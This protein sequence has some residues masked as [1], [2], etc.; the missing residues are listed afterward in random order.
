MTTN[1]NNKLLCDDHKL[2]WW[3]LMIFINE[4]MNETKVWEGRDPVPATA[5]DLLIDCAMYEYQTFHW[6]SNSLLDIKQFTGYQ[7]VY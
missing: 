3:L 1:Y 4:D 5:W 2:L 7:T 6:L